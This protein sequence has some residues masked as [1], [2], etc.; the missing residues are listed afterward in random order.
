MAKAINMRTKS[1][2]NRATNPNINVTVQRFFCIFLRMLITIRNIPIENMIIGKHIRKNASIG[3]I[4]IIR[5]AR[6]TSAIK[7]EPII[8]SLS[9]F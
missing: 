1:G 6:I 5:N 3:S 8:R 9:F 7:M 2:Y 4:S